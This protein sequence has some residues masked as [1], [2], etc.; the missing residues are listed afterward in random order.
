[1]KK[2]NIYIS[3]KISGLDL[4][5]VKKL[6]DSAKITINTWR[7]EYKWNRPEYGDAIS[8]LDLDHSKNKKW[9]DYMITDI[10]ALWPC[11]AIYMLKNWKQSNGARIEWFIAL[12]NFKKIYYEK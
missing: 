5:D 12:I 6:F 8:P 4:E 10:I 9:I 1:M 7:R 3:G 2:H 11:D